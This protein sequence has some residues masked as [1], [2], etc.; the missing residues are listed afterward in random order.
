P[1][2]TVAHEGPV[3]ERPM[4][5]P[6]DLDDLEAD[7]AARL[8]PPATPD[9]LPDHPLAA[10]GVR[11][12]AGPHALRALWLAVVSSPDGADKTWVTEQYDR[13]VRGNTVLAQPADAGV[14]RID[15]GSHRGIALALDGNARYARLDPYTGAQLNLAE[16]YRNV[17]VSGATPLAVTNCLNFGSPEEPEVMWQFAEAV[18]GLADARRALGPPG[19]GGNLSLSPPHDV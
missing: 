9:A 13:Y 7:D 19:I 11:S 3:Y 4:Q 16:A 2:R 12:R 15:E 14:V 17:A 8:P 18:R 5:R 1:P 6:A 10:G